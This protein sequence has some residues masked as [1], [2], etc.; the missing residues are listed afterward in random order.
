MVVKKAICAAFAVCLIFF[1][2]ACSFT[3]ISVTDPPQKI[4][5]EYIEPVSF[6]S[7]RAALSASDAIR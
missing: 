6:L 3:G 2:S 1:L 7:F 5:K 4:Y